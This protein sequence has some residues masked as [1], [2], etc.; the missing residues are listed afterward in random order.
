ATPARGGSTMLTW[1][2][3]LLTVAAVV[4]GVWV[5]RN[6]LRGSPPAPPP[7]GVHAGGDRCGN[8]PI[9]AEVIV[10]CDRY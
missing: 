5:V 2:F 10:T 1:A 7:A 4:V 6:A 8:Q 3:I 9:G